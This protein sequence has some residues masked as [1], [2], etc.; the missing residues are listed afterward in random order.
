MSPDVLLECPRTS[1]RDVLRVNVTERVWIFPISDYVLNLPFFRPS[2]S[3]LKESRN[4]FKS[5]QTI[6]SRSEGDKT[7]AQLVQVHLTLSKS[8][9]VVDEKGNFLQIFLHQSVLVDSSPEKRGAMTVTQDS[10]T[11]IR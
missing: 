10:R 1:F 9:I 2:L 6:F 3:V 11:H 8:A 7:A 4:N 5:R